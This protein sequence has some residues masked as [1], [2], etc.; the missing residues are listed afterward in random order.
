MFKQIRKEQVDTLIHETG[1][2]FGLRHFFANV[3]ETA[4]PSKVFGKHDKFTIMNY[5]HD[6]ELTDYDKS[7]LKRLYKMAWS[8][9]L[10]NINGTPIRLI[11][12]FHTIGH[13]Q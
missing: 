12:P 1:H 3:T 8:G 5:G 7:D 9:E 2:I 10:E 6:S 4:W 13:P 11:K